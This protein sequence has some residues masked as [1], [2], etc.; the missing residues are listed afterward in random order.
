MKRILCYGLFWALFAFFLL[1]GKQR[2]LVGSAVSKRAA[3]MV[4]EQKAASSTKKARPAA[5]RL[6]EAEFDLL[7][8]RSPWPKKLHRAV[9]QVA[10]CESSWRP[11]AKGPTD[12]H[13]LLQ[14]RHA[15]HKEKVSDRADLYDP[16][17]NL[18]IAYAVYLDAER[19]KFGHGF[20]PWY[21]SNKCHKLLPQTV[22]SHIK[23]FR[24]KKFVLAKAQ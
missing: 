17:V 12:D 1:Q 15:A 6:S 24:T 3:E 14:I 21:M 10:F 22:A 7:L 13:G 8:A 4:K 18:R 5:S 19:G 16:A 9:K 11:H 20:A 23:K 2:E